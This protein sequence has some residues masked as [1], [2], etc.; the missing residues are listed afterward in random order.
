MQVEDRGFD[1]VRSLVLIFSLV[2]SRRN[3]SSK[4]DIH[5]LAV[6]T[7]QCTFH[8]LYSQVRNNA[9]CRN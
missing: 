9:N 4:P 8:K 7:Q 6:L 3:N 1:I 2:Y 5:I